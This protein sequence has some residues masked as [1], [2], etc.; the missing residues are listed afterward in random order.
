MLSRPTFSIRKLIPSPQKKP[1]GPEEG[2]EGSYFYHDDDEDMDTLS[3][4]KT[5]RPPMG[6]MKRHKPSIDIRR[7][8]DLHR[9]IC[10]PPLPDTPQ[11]S[12]TSLCSID[13]GATGYVVSASP[14]SSPP[15]R[16]D[17]S[18]LASPLMS[19]QRSP[20][21]S[22]LLLPQQFEDQQQPPRGRSPVPVHTLQ[23]PQL[24]PPSSP[25]QQAEMALET[26]LTSPDTV[27]STP[28]TYNSK[29]P[30]DSNGAAV[31]SP[32]VQLL[33]PESDEAPALNQ[34]LSNAKLSDH[35]LDKF[36][37]P[38]D[39]S[40]VSGPV[41]RKSQRRSQGSVKSVK[42]PTKTSMK[43]PLLPA[44]ARLQSNSRPKRAKSKK[45]R[46]RPRAP[47]R[48]SSMWQLTESAKDLF[49]IRIF[50]RIEVDEMLPESTLREIRMSRAAHWTRSPELGVTHV[51]SKSTAAAPIEPLSLDDSPDAAMGE[52]VATPRASVVEQGAVIYEEDCKTPTAPPEMQLMTGEG[53]NGQAR[54]EEQAGESQPAMQLPDSPTTKSYDGDEEDGTLPIMMMVEDDPTAQPQVGEAK[55]APSPMPPMKAPMHRRM[56]SRQLPPLPTIPEIVTTAPEEVLMSPTS[57]PPLGSASKPN[58]DDYL[59]LDSNPCTLTM[60]A[61]RHGRIRLSKSDLPINKLAAA[62]DDTLDW[63]AFQM[64]ILGG[65]GDFF[66]E[67]TDYSR[68]SEAELDELEQL[69]SWYS[70]FGFDGAGSLVG[71]SEPRTPTQPWTPVLPRTPVLSPPSPTSTPNSSP[72]TVATRSPGIRRIDPP[73][74]TDERGAN[75]FP[76]GDSIAGRF[77]PSPSLAPAGPGYSRHRRSA[78][79]TTFG[80]TP[81]QHKP[82]LTHSASFESRNHAGLAIDSTRRPSVD[83]IQSLPQSPMMD[84]VVSHDVEGN[85]YMVPMGFNLSHDLGDFLNWHAEHVSGAGFG[86]A[87]GNQI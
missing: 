30:V 64:A 47:A 13:N 24:T 71:P 62:V 87:E 17:R 15:R 34:V 46:R 11:S 39:P 12:T 49:T 58:T 2:Y 81:A 48:Q 54:V 84:L 36:P 10:I 76:L 56:P 21:R 3:K 79:S 29:T 52:D 23:A 6:L 55:L 67:P 69:A 7:S 37:K 61:I 63:T 72:R 25:P 50:H 38:K 41:R 16:P 20:E 9:I 83:S 44:Q 26:P 32:D 74:A 28:A 22:P 59:F 65:A 19:P 82:K 51:D 70:E 31:S 43:D 86:P 1:E 57:A 45:S 66:S 53:V 42:S 40:P 80:Q 85:E 5:W 75:S 78:S 60:P 73:V 35:E 18:P 4:I 68:P 27:P 14:R 8:E 77:F 33:T